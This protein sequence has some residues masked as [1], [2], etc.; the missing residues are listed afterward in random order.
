[1]RDAEWWRDIHEFENYFDGHLVRVLLQTHKSLIDMANV[2][3]VELDPWD[4]PA[5]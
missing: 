5:A 1:L 2:T 3:E 4:S